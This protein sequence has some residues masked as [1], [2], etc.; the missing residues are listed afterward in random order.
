MTIWLNTLTTVLSTFFWLIP[1]I[2]KDTFRL[3]IHENT[4]EASDIGTESDVKTF[5][6]TFLI[7]LTL[8]FCLSLAYTA[9]YAYKCTAEVPT[10]TLVLKQRDMKTHE[11][12]FRPE[13]DDGE[14]MDLHCSIC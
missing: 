10:D 12:Y 4:A 5:S 1:A 2:A 11:E 3:G 13:W 14:P 8:I 6:A 9:Y 7:L